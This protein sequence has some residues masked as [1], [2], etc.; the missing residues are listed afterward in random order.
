MPVAHCASPPGTSTAS[1]RASATSPIGCARARPTSSACRRSRAST[2]VPARRDRGAWLQCR[3]PRPEGFQRRRAAVEAAVRRGQRGLP[4]DDGRRAGAL[5]RRRVLDRQGRRCASPRS[6]CRTA[7]RSATT[8]N[9]P[10]SWPGWR[11]WSAGPSERLRLEEPLVLAGDY[12][13]IPEPV[14]A[15]SRRT[16]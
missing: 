14:D 5:H 8:R 16:G 13:V 2:T 3:S 9:S 4:G 11:G 1:A 15:R 6:I 10:T 7:I 12:N